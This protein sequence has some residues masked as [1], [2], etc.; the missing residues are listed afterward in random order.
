[1]KEWTSFDTISKGK[2]VWLIDSNGNKIWEQSFGGINN[3]KGVGIVPSS[4][5]EYVIVGST[6]SYGAGNYDI[7]LLKV[8]TE[9]IEN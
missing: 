9:I 4:D 2:G 8:S 1:M 5:G 6:E 3:D 7:W